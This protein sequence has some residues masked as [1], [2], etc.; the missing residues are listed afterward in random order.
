MKNDTRHTKKQWKKFINERILTTDKLTQTTHKVSENVRFE[1]HTHIKQ[2][3]EWSRWG[4]PRVSAPQICQ[5]RYRSRS[6][7]NRPALLTSYTKVT[8]PKGTG[9]SHRSPCM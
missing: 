3:E 2:E 9:P 4:M 6:V 7:R 5:K 8:S 1:L